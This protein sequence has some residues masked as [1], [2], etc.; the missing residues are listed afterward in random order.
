MAR[1]EPL[2]RELDAALPDRPF[3]LE[4]W[5]GSRAARH[6][7]RRPPFR[8]RSHGRRRPTP[9]RAP[10]QLG[11]GRAYVSGA[12]EVDDLD[13]VL[14]LLD[15]WSPPPLGAAREGAADGR[16]GCARAGPDA[17]AARPRRRAQAEGP[18]PQPRARPPLGPPPLRR[19]QRVLQAVPRRLADLLVRDLLA[20][21]E[22]ARG[23]PA[24]QARAG[25]RQA[26]DRRGRPRARR[27]LRLGELHAAAASRG[28]QVT[29]ITLSEP[30]AQLARAARRRGRPRR[31]DRHP[32]HGLARAARRALRQDR[33]DRHGRARRQR[34]HRRLR[35]P[36]RRAAGARRA[37]PQPR[38]RAPAPLTTPRPARSPSASC[39]P[40][41]RRCTCRAS[42]R[43]SSAPGCRST[44]SRA[45]RA[46][47]PRR[48]ATG[49]RGSTR[50]LDEAV[51]LGGPERVRVW[52]LYLR[53]ARRGFE[54][55]FTSVYQV[56]AAPA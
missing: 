12:L 26:R 20:R 34:E 18:P 22:D 33:L 46:T 51:R 41:R 17:P 30:Q 19:L 47:T 9:L 15:E 38:H 52:R 40:T 23:G 48:C 45:S 6:Q 21:R 24:H 49:R 25:R 4:L 36:P 53:A 27:R 11:L 54:S 7:R 31:P 39:S 3:H 5:D 10:G 28:A 56:R 44:T 29:G 43:R 2:L 50:N 8:A 13:A 37:D 14:A 1:T 16:R 32:R 35:R 55:G 42:S